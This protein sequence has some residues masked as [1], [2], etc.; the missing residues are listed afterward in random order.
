MY[1]LTYTQT[2]KHKERDVKR[3]IHYPFLRFGIY[4][5]L[6]GDGWVGFIYKCVSNVRMRVYTRVCTHTHAHVHTR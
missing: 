4:L 1:A 2:H 5:K 3:N 6:F